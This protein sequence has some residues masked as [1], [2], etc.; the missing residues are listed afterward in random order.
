[1]RKN[2]TVCVVVSMWKKNTLSDTQDTARHVPWENTEGER[3]VVVAL[4]N[5]HMAV[6]LAGKMV[7]TI[8]IPEKNPGF[9]HFT[10]YDLLSAPVTF[11]AIKGFLKFKNIQNNCKGSFRK[12]RS[13]RGRSLLIIWCVCPYICLYGSFQYAHWNTWV[14]LVLFVFASLFCFCTCC[15]AIYWSNVTP[16]TLWVMY[17]LLRCL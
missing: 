11:C 17:F 16:V 14:V 9:H 5:V 12:Y 6:V 1:M 15:R 3:A 8:H 7:Q 4:N 13:D 2:K 10:A